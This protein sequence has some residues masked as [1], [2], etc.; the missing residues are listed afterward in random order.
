MM[1]LVVLGAAVAAIAACETTE[2][3]PFVSNMQSPDRTERTYAEA[4][5]PD[6]MRCE[7]IQVIGSRMPAERV[8]QTEEEWARMR[9]NSQEIARDI[10]RQ[11]IPLPPAG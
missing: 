10:E 8:C 5:T 2:Y 9:D 11:P 4:E 1:R 7:S 6:G 3:D